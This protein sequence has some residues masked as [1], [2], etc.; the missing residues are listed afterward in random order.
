MR[1]DFKWR[2]KLYRDEIARLLQHL[3][4]FYLVVFLFYFRRLQMCNKCCNLFYYTW[5]HNFTHFWQIHIMDFEL[6]SLLYNQ[7]LHITCVK[8][9]KL[10]LVDLSLEWRTDSRTIYWWSTH[11]SNGHLLFLLSAQPALWLVYIILF[12]FYVLICVNLCI[13]CVLSARVML[14]CDIWYKFG[15]LVFLNEIFG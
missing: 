11:L 9:S 4:Y 6:N 2:L 10:A 8:H 15:F 13:F 14:V 7:R 5:S 12:N 1:W 3:F